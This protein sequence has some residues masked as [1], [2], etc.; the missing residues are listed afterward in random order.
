[1]NLKEILILIGFI[2][3][4]ALFITFFLLLLLRE[5]EEIPEINSPRELIIVIII[6]IEILILSF[7]ISMIGIGNLLEEIQLIKSMEIKK[8]GIRTMAIIKENE[9]TYELEFTT[10]DGKIIKK[11]YNESAFGIKLYLGFSTQKQIPVVYNGKNPKEVVIDVWWIKYVNLLPWVF[12]VSGLCFFG[13]LI[14]VGSFKKLIE[15]NKKEK[16]QL[17]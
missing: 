8:T 3:G 9:K 6:G 1:M 11:E 16:Q 14:I 5:K 10:Y 17:L 2:S 12:V 4:I 7:S 13:I 15:Q